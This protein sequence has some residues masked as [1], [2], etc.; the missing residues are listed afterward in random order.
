MIDLALWYERTKD[1]PWAKEAYDG[2]L[3][4]IRAELARIEENLNSEAPDFDECERRIA[5]LEA[6]AVA[7]P[8]GGTLDECLRLRAVSGFLRR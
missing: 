5:A 2:T 4:Q 3:P 8:W 1:L 6:E 7:T